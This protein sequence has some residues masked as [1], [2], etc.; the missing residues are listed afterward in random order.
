[1]VKE[2]NTIKIKQAY[3]SCCFKQSYFDQIYFEQ[4]NYNYIK[5]LNFMDNKKW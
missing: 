4:N 5:L 3:N 1:M 2:D